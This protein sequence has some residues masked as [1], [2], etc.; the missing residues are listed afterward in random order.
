MT[1]RKENVEGPEV[2]RLLY[3]SLVRLRSMQQPV[4]RSNRRP[5]QQAGK[6]NA[7][8]S[9]YGSYCLMAAT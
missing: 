2:T 1:G 5:I 8:S 9:E 3:G 4:Q 6:E 7:V